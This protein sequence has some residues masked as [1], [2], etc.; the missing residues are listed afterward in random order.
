MQAGHDAC[1]LA[2]TG[3]PVK[4]YAVRPDVADRCG[5]R[6]TVAVKEVGVRAV[7]HGD[8]D[9]ARKV[10]EVVRQLCQARVLCP[11][12]GKD[13]LRVSDQVGPHL[14]YRGRTCRGGACHAAAGAAA[15][16]DVCPASQDD[17]RWAERRL[18]MAMTAV[19]P[20]ST[21]ASS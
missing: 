7:H 9:P 14:P 18:S 4:G 21:S 17:I 5:K 10:A 2:V 20:N 6:G 16:S 19:A 1:N 13:V 15:R 11:A 12:Q 8:G 3:P